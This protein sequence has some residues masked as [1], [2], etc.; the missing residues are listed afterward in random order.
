MTRPL[1]C[2]GKSIRNLLNRRLGGPKSQSGCCGEETKILF[3]PGNP[4][5]RGSWLRYYAKSRKVAVSIPVEV[6]GFFFN[7]PN[8]SS[9]NMALGSSQPLT[10]MSTRNLPAGKGRLACKADNITAISEQI[11]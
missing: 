9:R 10:E 4:G 8:I 6:I 7:L 1:Y 11:V 2:K 5:A 3:P